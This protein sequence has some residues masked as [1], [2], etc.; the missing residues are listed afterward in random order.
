MFLHLI[1]F[2]LCLGFIDIIHRVLFEVPHPR[3][4]KQKLLLL[5]CIY[6]MSS[7]QG[8]W[9]Q[10]Q[11]QPQEFVQPHRYPLSTGPS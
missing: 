4:F 6:I 7:Y 10:P 11:R 3:K 2:L 8:Q 1:K 5:L 9:S